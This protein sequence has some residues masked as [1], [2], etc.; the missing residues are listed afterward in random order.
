MKSKRVPSF[1][2]MKN[3]KEISSLLDGEIKSKSPSKQGNFSG[4]REGSGSYPAPPMCIST[5]CLEP[6]GG[7]GGKKREGKKKKREEGNHVTGNRI[8]RIGEGDKITY[9]TVPSYRK[10]RIKKSCSEYL[11]K[12]DRCEGDEEDC[13]VKHFKDFCDN[14]LCPVCYTRW[15]GIRSIDAM[16][17]LVV[18]KRVWEGD[19][20]PLEGDYYQYIVSPPQ[21]RSLEILREEGYEG[22]KILKERFKRRWVFAEDNDHMDMLVVFHLFRLTRKAWAERKDYNKG[23]D[24]GEKLGKWEYVQVKGKINSKYVKLGPHFHVIS[25]NRLMDSGDFADETALMEMYEEERGCNALLWDRG[26]KK[27]GKVNRPVKRGSYYQSWLTKRGRE[28]TKKERDEYSWIYD[29]KHK[30]PLRTSDDLKGKIYYLLSHSTLFYDER[31][32]DG[33]PT[34]N[35]GVN[36][37][38]KNSLS[39]HG[40]LST[41][42]LRHQED[43][44]DLGE[45]ECQA[46]GGLVYEY[47]GLDIHNLQKMK[48]K[49]SSLYSKFLMKKQITDFFEELLRLHFHFYSLDF[50]LKLKEKIICDLDLELLGSL[51]KS[52]E[53]VEYMIGLLHRFHRQKKDL[54]DLLNEERIFSIHERGEEILLD[55]W[56]YSNKGEVCHEYLDLGVWFVNSEDLGPG[57]P[58]ELFLCDLCDHIVRFDDLDDFQANHWNVENENCCHKYK[59]RLGIERVNEDLTK[60]GS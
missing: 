14:P 32:E 25:T 59:K 47:L 3:V 44:L 17:R 6:G 57:P 53:V 20:F 34:V 10:F 1:V 56:T 54:K 45:M 29:K 52:E 13:D 2:S 51:V 9:V 15:I 36:V 11:S 50:V 22:V 37:R 12:V 18:G 60:F 8:F 23:L 33:P 26:G 46:C 27:D 28:V 7:K 41:K 42:R 5:E 35:G 4:I 58:R 48:K 55:D 38:K 19:G 31:P 49:G 21:K 39:Y 43:Y 30:N 24:K 16:N 40:R